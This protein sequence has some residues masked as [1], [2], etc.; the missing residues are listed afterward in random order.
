MPLH[1]YICIFF[2]CSFAHNFLSSIY[3][4][5]TVCTMH[6]S[7]LSLSLSLSAAE[8]KRVGDTLLGV[9]TQCVQVKN[10]LKPSAQTLSNLCLKIN[11]KLGG[12]NSILVPGIRY[13]GS[14]NWE[15]VF[16]VFHYIH[17]TWTHILIFSCFIMHCL[18]C[19]CFCW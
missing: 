3:I 7:Q 11:V 12:V 6:V 19:L 18:K 15:F 9:A 17:C 5:R 14:K 16:S 1:I 8:V 13:F 2:I 4:H 10:V